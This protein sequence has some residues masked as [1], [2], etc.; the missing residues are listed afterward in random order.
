MRRMLGTNLRAV[1]RWFGVIVSAVSV[2][3]AIFTYFGFWNEWRG[4][5]LAG[6]AAARFDKSYTADASRPVRV[7]DKEWR[8]L[9]RLIEQY[10]H[11][12]L[13]K[14][15][16]PLVLARSV[17]LTSVKQEATG[18]EWTAPTTPLIL[19]YKEWPNQG[20]LS[21]DDWLVV[22]TIEDLHNWI[23][24][25]GA[26]FDFLVRTIIFGIL[27]VCVGVF[28]ALPESREKTKGQ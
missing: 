8:P 22:G 5:N 18:S 9:M 4:D 10:S 27:S 17:A 26:D 11:A 3:F 20:D 19:L 21:R 24:T 6:A 15:K 12:D 2:L 16:K 25:D 28:L 14:D 23:R 1:A 7:G 13:P